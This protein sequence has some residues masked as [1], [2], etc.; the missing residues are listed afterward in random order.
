MIHVSTNTLIHRE[1]TGLKD[2]ATILHRN[3]KGITQTLFA[4]YVL[5][6]LDNR[7]EQIKQLQTKIPSKYYI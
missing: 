5:L 6:Q 7:Y 1:Y 3:L 2:E 4:H